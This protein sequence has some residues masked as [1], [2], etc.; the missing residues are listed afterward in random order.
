[1]KYRAK[2]YLLVPEAYLHIS[3]ETKYGTNFRCMLNR[4]W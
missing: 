2:I 1:M 4:K 3:V